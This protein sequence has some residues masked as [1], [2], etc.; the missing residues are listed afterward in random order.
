[1]GHFGLVHLIMFRCGK[2]VLVLI[3]IKFV[4]YLLFQ[5]RQLF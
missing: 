2:L 4:W 3:A 1:M 5:F